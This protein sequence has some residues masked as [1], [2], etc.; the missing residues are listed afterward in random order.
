[1][2]RGGSDIDDL[3]L[4][5]LIDHHFGGMARA[6]PNT[7]QADV[8]DP[9]PLFF[10]NIKNVF[11]IGPGSLINKN[12]TPAPFLHHR[13]HHLLHRTGRGNVADHRNGAARILGIDLA[14][15]ATPS[16]LV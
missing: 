1:M 2:A 11:V 3:S 6:V 4:S 16:S 15:Y 9:I 13:W 14:R 12:I 5:F 10:R 7:P 8:H